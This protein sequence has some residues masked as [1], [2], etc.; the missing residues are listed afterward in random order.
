MTTGYVRCDDEFSEIDEDLD[1]SN[2]G[3]VKLE[4]LATPFNGVSPDISRELAMLERYTQRGE[5]YKMLKVGTKVMIRT[6]KEYG[7]RLTGKVGTISRILYKAEKVGVHFDD[8][9]NPDGN[10]GLF[11]IPDRCVTPYSPPVAMLNADNVKEVIFNGNKTIVI[12]ADGTK[13]I[14][15]C[16]EGDSYD[17]Y[18]GFCAAVVKYVFGSTGEAKRILKMTSKIQSVRKKSN[19]VDKEDT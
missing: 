8:I 18:A 10:T 11:W 3:T 15:G 16:G 6:C 14:V 4:P 12:W 17:P 5:K 19:H 1:M 13:T 7:G 9:T 2:F